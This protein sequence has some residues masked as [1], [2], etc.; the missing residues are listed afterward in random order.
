[1]FS[2]LIDDV[3][4]TTGNNKPLSTSTNYNIRYDGGAASDYL[5]N[6]GALAIGDVN[7]DRLSD[8][9][10]GAYG[11]DNN[12]SYSGSA[13]V[14][15]GSIYNRTSVAVY[16]SNDTLVSASSP[17]TQAPPATLT[18]LADDD[19]Y[20]LQ[21]NDSI[22]NPGYNSQVYKFTTNFDYSVFNNPRFTVDWQGYG[23]TS[24]TNYLYLWNF[25]LSQWEE[26]DNGVMITDTALSGYKDGTSYVSNNTL[27]AWLK[28][29]HVTGGS[30]LFT[31]QVKIAVM[32][33]PNTI[34]SAPTNFYV[35]T[36]TIGAQSG[37]TNPGVID[38]STPVFSSQFVDSDTGDTSTL[39]QVVVYSDPSCTTQVYSSGD[40]GTAQTSCTEGNR[41]ADFDYGG[42]SLPFNGKKYYYKVRYF[43][44]CGAGTYS[45]CTE[46]FTMLGPD[47]QMRHGNYFDITRSEK[48]FSW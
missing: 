44:A 40:S 8:L 48:D 17:G 24:Q 12:G 9:V 32:P 41:C 43:D 3:G 22:A 36:S 7:G 14:I 15:D 25:T 4:A 27:W 5:T 26:I 34:P 10:L 42:T 19:A 31:D 20:R 38:D 13:W 1:M 28:Q 6:G 39:Y 2:T 46:N 23:E 18:R 11:A 16:E 29:T 37:Y 33:V 30:G 45:A 21:T 47:V 35:S